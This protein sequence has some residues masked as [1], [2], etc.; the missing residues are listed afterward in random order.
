MSLRR[1]TNLQRARAA[2]LGSRRSPWRSRCQP[3]AWRASGWGFGK[4]PSIRPEGRRPRNP[5]SFNRVSRPS[6]PSDLIRRTSRSAK[7]P[8]GSACRPSS[9]GR[10]PSSSG[11]TRSRTRW[12]PGSRWR[13]ISKSSPRARAASGALAHNSTA[14]TSAPSWSGSIPRRTRS[15][16]GSPKSAVPWRSA[17]GLSG[18]SIAR[19]P[20]PIPTAVPCS[21]S[22]RRPA[23]SPQG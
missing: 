21:G 4:G 20:A 22:T 9:P 17:T 19:E 10:T 7:V 5:S 11:S 8:Y 16:G 14:A 6:C 1:P 15:W 18:R 2:A 23:R 3:P 12:S 13:A